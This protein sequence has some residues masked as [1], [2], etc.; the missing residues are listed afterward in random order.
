M[1]LLITFF[2]I[3]DFAVDACTPKRTYFSKIGSSKIIIILSNISAKNLEM[4]VIYSINIQD[5]TPCSCHAGFPAC[6]ALKMIPIKYIIFQPYMY[7]PFYHSQILVIDAF[8]HCQLQ[9]V[10]GICLQETLAIS[11]VYRQEKLQK[12]LILQKE[13]K[14]HIGMCYSSYCNISTKL[15]KEECTKYFV[16]AFHKSSWI[17]RCARQSGSFNQ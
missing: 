5:N 12:I 2:S 15:I 8:C 14:S 4:P 17:G 11:A 6:G 10:P 13:D 7:I 1:F 16:E 9:L 3:R